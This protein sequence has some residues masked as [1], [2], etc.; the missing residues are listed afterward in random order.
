MR[1]LLLAAGLGNRLRPITDFTPKPLLPIVDR[2]I[3][4][5]NI[6]RL[7]KLGIEKIGVNLFYKPEMIKNYINKFSDY[8]H[9]EHENRLKGT[10]GALVNFHKFFNDNFLIHNSDIVTD[11]D[12]AEAVDIH[13]CQNAI[14]TLILTKNSGTNAVMID[15][16]HQILEFSTDDDDKYTYTGIAILSDKIFLYLPNK[17]TFSIIEVYQKIIDRGKTIIGIPTRGMWY[18]IGSHVRYWQIHH[19]LLYKK[20]DFKELAIKSPQ[21]I[22]PTSTVRTDTLEGFISIGPN[23][24]VSDNVTLQDTVVFE[25]SRILQGNF[26]NCLLSDKFCVEVK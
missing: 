22:A 20:F 11:I 12:I 17:E 2:R 3:I 23:C 14:A 18:D 25:N 15:K 5:I 26:T 13:R 19:D 9:I 1:A 24:F 7:L 21:Y 16:E 6:A 8:I 4:D 10:G